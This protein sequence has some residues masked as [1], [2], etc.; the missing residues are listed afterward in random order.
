MIII[1]K[2]VPVSEKTGRRISGAAAKSAAAK[3]QSDLAAIRVETATKAQFSTVTLPKPATKSR[4]SRKVVTYDDFLC[5]GCGR[6]RSEEGRQ[7][8]RRPSHQRWRQ[9]C[10]LQSRRGPLVGAS[11]RATS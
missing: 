8:V 3:V 10:R 9:V 5:Q 2:L 11:Q 4:R 6:I 7:E 1:K